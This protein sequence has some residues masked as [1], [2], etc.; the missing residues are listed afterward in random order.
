MAAMP[1]AD[2]EI[3]NAIASL[4]EAGEASDD[5]RRLSDDARWTLL[6]RARKALA[7]GEPAPAC[8]CAALGERGPVWWTHGA[9]DFNHLA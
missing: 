7:Q 8:R 9:P 1:V 2:E 4:L 6:R 5:R 3:R